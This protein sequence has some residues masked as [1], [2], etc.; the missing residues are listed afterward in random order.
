MTVFS[1]QLSSPH[2]PLSV[3]H[4]GNQGLFCQSFSAEQ[5]SVTQSEGALYSGDALPLSLFSPNSYDVILVDCDFYYSR[6]NL[7]GLMY[8]LK[9]Q[10][11]IYLRAPMSLSVLFEL[12]GIEITA[13]GN[14][15]IEVQKRQKY[16][17]SDISALCLQGNYH[18]ALQVLNEREV[19]YPNELLVVNIKSLLEFYLGKTQQALQSL[20]EGSLR[21]IGQRLWEA[22]ALFRLEEDSWRLFSERTIQIEGNLNRDRFVFK[23]QPSEKEWLAQSL[24]G[25]HIVILR[26]YGLGDMLMFAQFAHLFKL[27]GAAKVS[28]ICQ[29]EIVAILQSS[30][31]I[32]AVYSLNDHSVNQLAYDYWLYP[33][34]ILRSIMTSF[35]QLPM[36]SPYLFA[37][38]EKKAIFLPKKSGKRLKIGLIWKGN[39][40]HENDAARSIHNLG[41]LKMLLEKNPQVQWVSLQQH[42]TSAEVQLLAEYQVISLGDSFADMADTAGA[43]A[44]LDYLVTVDTSVA[45]LAGAMGVKTLLMLPFVVDWR[46]G[47]AETTHWY[48]S[49]RLF[50]CAAPIPDWHKPIHE[51]SAFLAHC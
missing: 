48:P 6:S 8:A 12:G 30:P 22:E 33:H 46:W 7:I 23:H 24:E 49:V 38:K 13:W 29:P 17:D 37:C 19:H 42:C 2:S 50:R 44:N 5:S 11:R 26:E 25:K 47:R 41:Y 39:P 51:I 28:I 36:R 4:I 10:G 43:L 20:R 21:I 15:F 1:M 14:D 16:A 18:E 35:V 34:N 31:D 27:A 40:T 3:W 45:H 9:G 32:D